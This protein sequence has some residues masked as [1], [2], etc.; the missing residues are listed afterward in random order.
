M[1]IPP[2]YNIFNPDFISSLNC[3]YRQRQARLATKT[4]LKDSSFKS[5]QR[6][7]NQLWP[8]STSDNHNCL[9]IS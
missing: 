5:N 7:G 1:V 6:R 9:L 2:L 4:W 3:D 8:D